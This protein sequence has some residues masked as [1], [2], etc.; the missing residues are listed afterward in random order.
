MFRG[1]AVF[2]Q[3]RCSS[4]Y[5]RHRLA[6]EGIV[7]LSVLSLVVF[8][9]FGKMQ[10]SGPSFFGLPCSCN[11]SGDNR[12]GSVCGHGRGH[13]RGVMISGSRQTAYSISAKIMN[14]ISGYY[15]ILCFQELNC[16]DSNLKCASQ[17]H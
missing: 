13:G 10:Q 17:T 12:S 1:G 6:R 7:T 4:C 14:V 3:T 8:L 9:I 11:V 15:I 16:A 5:L 2:F